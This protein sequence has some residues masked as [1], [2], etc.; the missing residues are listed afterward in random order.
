M[1]GNMKGKYKIEM[2]GDYNNECY[3]NHTSEL[4]EPHDKVKEIS[5]L[6]YPKLLNVV[7]AG[8][9]VLEKY[10]GDFVINKPYVSH[11]I[12]TNTSE[13]QIIGRYYSDVAPIYSKLGFIDILREVD[14]TDKIFNIKTVTKINDQVKEIHKHTIFKDN[15]YFFISSEDITASEMIKY[16]EEKLFNSPS[17]GTFEITENYKVKRMNNT[18]LKM[19]GYSFEELDKMTFDDFILYYENFNPTVSSYKDAFNKLFNREIVLSQGQCK[20]RKKDGDIRWLETTSIIINF[21]EKIIQTSVLDITKTKRSEEKALELEK[22]LNYISKNSKIAMLYAAAGKL[23]YTSE[24]ENIVEMSFSEYSQN[25]YKCILNDDKEMFIKKLQSLSKKEPETNVSFKIKTPSGKIKYL[26]YYL[27]DIYGDGDNSETY[28]YWGFEFKK[29]KGFITSIALIQDITDTVNKEIELKNLADDKEVLLKEI[30]HRV[31]NN[32][33]LILSY[34]NLEKHFNK[35]DPEIIVSSIQSRIQNIALLHE[36]IYGSKDLMNINLKDYISDQLKNQI[37]LY[38]IHDIESKINIPSDLTA[39]VDGTTS[40]GLIL[41]EIFTN[42]LKYGFDSDDT[43]KEFYVDIKEDNGVIIIRC[44][45]NGKG[46]PEDIDIYESP[47]LGLT[48]INQLTEQLD[49]IFEKN[50]TEIGTSYTFKFKK[51][52]F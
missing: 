35:D 19:L 22:N 30:H 23:S 49:G 10:K 7:G 24:L 5:T 6:Q 16:A 29:E 25:F 39:S 47:S 13:E 48:I 31:K 37:S 33:Q 44:G 14:K 12:S 50:E 38:G 32:L 3:F 27:K 11:L 34:I 26:K 15:D 21:K 36:K 1:K 17:Q 28:Y 51:E 41:D 45:D 8:I 46:L 18:F 4:Y 43:N 2:S 52:K 40:F 9:F 20:I 42:T